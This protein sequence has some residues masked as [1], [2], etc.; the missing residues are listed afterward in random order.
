[1][2]LAGEVIDNGFH[3]LQVVHSVCY[4][5]AAAVVSVAFSFASRTVKNDKDQRTAS[6]IKPVEYA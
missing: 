1:M 2:A 6:L 3:T 4:A 5:I